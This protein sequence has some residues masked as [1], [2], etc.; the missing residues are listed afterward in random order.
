[1]QRK[2]WFTLIQSPAPLEITLRV[3]KSSS[4]LSL[5]TFPSHFFFSLRMSSDN[6]WTTMCKAL[7]TC[8]KSFMFLRCQNNALLL[9]EIILLV[10]NINFS[11]CSS[12]NG[13]TRFAQKLICLCL[14]NPHRLIKYL[15]EGLGNFLKVSETP[16]KM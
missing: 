8:P 6:K 3:S 7:S 10:L 16:L 4:K 14:S 15:S 13:D 1:M 11:I 2:Q 9:P 12:L 5:P